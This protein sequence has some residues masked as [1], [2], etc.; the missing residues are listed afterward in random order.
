MAE[1]R[2]WTYACALMVSG[3][4]R[5]VV[6]FFSS[7]T[8]TTT[9]E[10]YEL[11]T[12]NT[13]PTTTRRFSTIRTYTQNTFVPAL[14]TTFTPLLVI[15]LL[16]SLVT[17]LTRT[18]GATPLPPDALLDILILTFPRPGDTKTHTSIIQSTLDSFASINNVN[19]YVYTHA[20]SSSHAALEALPALY[21][22]V[23]FT[24]APH[25]LPDAGKYVDAQHLH[26]ASALGWYKQNREKKV[27]GRWLMLM[28]DDFPLCPG[29]GAD[30]LGRTMWILEGNTAVWK[31]AWIGTGG[32]GL[33]FPNTQLPALQHTL[34]S[35]AKSDLVPSRK[36]KPAD[37][38]MQDCL[39]G[40][41]NLC[42]LRSSADTPDATTSPNTI[43]PAVQADLRTLQTPNKNAERNQILIPSRLST[44]HIGGLLS[45]TANKA[46]NT[47]KW[48][49]G[50]RHVLEGDEGV[51][52]IV[53]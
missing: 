26:L 31:G 37:V 7:S 1:N 36:H 40:R 5:L 35:Y 33:I 44:D 12:T 10:E 50:W 8:T 53:V 24:S 25:V 52:V 19:V 48:R 51:G 22:Q 30:V 29:Y 11:P 16:T 2:P 43:P 45:T 34:L 3:L 47:D 28:E 23:E 13:A 42:L 46:Q 21:P 38:V 14:K 27:K 17:Y 39:L 18:H 6:P 15:Y 20:P 41:E 9:V 49:C 32:S 4:V